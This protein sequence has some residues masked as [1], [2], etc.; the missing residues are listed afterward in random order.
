MELS[1]NVHITINDIKSLMENQKGSD[2]FR[3]W[4]TNEEVEEIFNNDNRI[5]TAKRS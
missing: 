2:P 3:G 4:L 5:L 1:V